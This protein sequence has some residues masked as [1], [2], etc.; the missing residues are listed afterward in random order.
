MWNLPYNTHCGLLP[1][2]SEQWPVEISLNCRFV[3]FF[4]TLL[5][6]DNSTVSY[7]T[8]IQSQN[9]RSI[10]GQNIRHIIVNNNLSWYEMQNYTTNAIKSHI[11]SKYMSNLNDDYISYAGVIRDLVL[12]ESLNTFLTEDES[13]HMLSFVC[14]T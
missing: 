2:V 14:T 8:R 7:L 13:N 10:F 9:C 11:Y 5:N 12:D 3:K 4:K 6:S 1:L